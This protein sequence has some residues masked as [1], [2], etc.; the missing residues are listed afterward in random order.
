M[1]TILKKD[2]AQLAVLLHK[3]KQQSINYLKQLN[4][5]ATRQDRKYQPKFYRK[6]C[7]L[8]NEMNLHS[9]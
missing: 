6:K 4:G 3:V 9:T 1:T 7:N 2:F 8:T 5:N